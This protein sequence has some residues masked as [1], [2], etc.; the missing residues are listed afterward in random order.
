LL[1]NNPNDI[2]NIKED[3]MST[4]SQN[5]QPQTDTVTADLTKVAEA[6]APKTEYNGAWVKS[7]REKLNL[8][9]QEFCEKVRVSQG[10]VSQVE[11]GRT[12]VSKK[13]KAKIESLLA[14][15]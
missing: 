11:K 14:S 6:N 15:N 4:N 10:L 8:T 5:T 3:N 7:V 12:P 9:Q 1:F 13:F 2:T